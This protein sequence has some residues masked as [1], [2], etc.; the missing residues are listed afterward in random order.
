MIHHPMEQVI[1]Y[2]RDSRH[3]SQC[4]QDQSG[5]AEKG[6][7][8]KREEEPEQ[9]PNDAEPIVKSPQLA[10]A[11]SRSFPIWHTHLNKFHPLIKRL[12]GHLR[13]YLKSSGDDRNLS[14]HSTIKDSVA[15]EDVRQVR[16]KYP[17]DGPAY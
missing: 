7:R 16:A 17:I 6:Q 1:M 9:V 13:F 4:Q 14:D 3:D 12:E 15:A 5:T 11:A 2:G 10:F 8:L